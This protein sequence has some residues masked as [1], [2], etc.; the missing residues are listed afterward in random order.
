MVLPIDTE[1]YAYLFYKNLNED[2]KLKSDEYGRWDIDFDF[3]NDDWYNVNGFDSVFNA[4]V[5]IIMTRFQELNFMSL[6][7]DFGCR[8]HE[9][10]K[11]NKSKNVVYNMEI[12]ITEV[13]ESMRRIKKV[14]WVVI[15]DNPDKEYY[16]YKVHFNVSCMIDEDYDEE[17]VDTTIIEES[18]LV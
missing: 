7:E 13:L 18:F 2:V 8:V 15:E 12:F 14:N 4:C 10:I 1:N 9:L 5:I 16:N 6:Y 3:E 17:D 11:A